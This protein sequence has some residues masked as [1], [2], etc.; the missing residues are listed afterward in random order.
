MSFNN[1]VAEKIK[2]FEQQGI[3][4]T[5][6]RDLTLGK[7]Q[8][9]A[10]GNL[11]NIVVGARRC[12]KTYRLFQEMNALTSSGVSPEQM[13][14]FNFED[15]RLKPYEPSLL[16]DVLDTFFAMY[17]H[18]R[19]AGAYLFLD[20]VQEVPEWGTFLRRAVDS[21]NVTMY[22]T[23]SS[24]KMLSAEL[25]SEFRGRSLARELFPLSFSEFVRYRN[26]AVPNCA[27]GLSAADKSLLRYE[28]GQYLVR[29]GFIVPLSLPLVDAMMLLQ[30]YASR[31]VAI[32]VVERYGLRNSRVASLFVSR[33][34]ASSA[35]ELSISKVY[36]EFKSRQVSVSRETLGNLL[37]YYE[38]AYLLFSVNEFSRSLADNARSSA[39]VYSVDPGMFAAFSPAISADEGQRLE[40]AVFNALR[41]TVPA[42]RRGS[43]CRLLLKDAS[44]AHEVDFVTGDALL[45]HAHQLVQ[46]SASLR[47]EKTRARELSALDV[48]MQQFGLKESVVVTMDEE[49]EEKLA[50]GTVHIVP[51]WKWLLL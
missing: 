49:S 15:E 44:R 7:L 2:E 3:P 38:D 19:E 18:A 47:D 40:T 17:H 48:A 30:D 13:L 32:D 46:V 9:P 51:A 12:G 22:V 41:R 37:A 50:A 39:K 16:G 14:Y 23:G 20:E 33:C 26:G 36:G 4:E 6:T 5:F 27:E 10:R 25:G 45:S 31:T 28:L 35:R 24:S 43:V 1:L 34:L 21:L 8:V 29:G 11:V 42:A